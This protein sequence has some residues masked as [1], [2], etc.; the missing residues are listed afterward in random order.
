METFWSHNVTWKSGCFPAPER[1]DCS[2]NSGI[3]QIVKMGP[4]L[5]RIA[6]GQV[7]F[8]LVGGA[9]PGSYS[10]RASGERNVIFRVSKMVK[11][12]DEVI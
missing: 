9:G 3:L 10:D 12:K 11:A 4:F 8:W 6:H 5:S 2:K 7:H 1:G